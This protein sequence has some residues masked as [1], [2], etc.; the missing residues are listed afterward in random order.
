M[1]ELNFRTVVWSATCVAAVGATAIWLHG[2]TSVSETV[3]AAPKLQVA[4]SITSEQAP[5]L[6]PQTPRVVDS[7]KPPMSHQSAA[8]TPALAMQ[9]RPILGRPL[10]EIYA[11]ALTA[12]DPKDRALAFQLASFCLGADSYRQPVEVGDVISNPAG[13]GQDPERLKAEVNDARARLLRECATVDTGAWMEGFRKLPMP[14]LD[15]TRIDMEGGVAVSRPQAH[16]Q[17]MTQVLSM[18]EAYP[19]PFSLWLENDLRPLLAREF[20]ASARQAYWVQ[21]ALIKTFLKDPGME[22]WVRSQRCAIAYACDSNATMSAEELQRAQAL[23]QLIEQRIRRQQWAQ[24][25]Q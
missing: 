1:F 6:A 24:L 21:D 3:A 23:A 4:G 5:S 8:S 14:R 22:I 2:R 19:V 17:A 20:Q 10:A 11:E 12:R 15:R 13:S 7:P 25:R 16:F 9:E 18:P